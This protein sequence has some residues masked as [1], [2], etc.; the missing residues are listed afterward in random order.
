M[1]DA[2]SRRSHPQPQTG[3][4]VQGHRILRATD[5]NSGIILDTKVV[6]D[7]GESKGLPPVIERV[8]KRL[9]TS[10]LIR[11]VVDKGFAGEPNLKAMDRLNVQETVI[12]QIKTSKHSER[13]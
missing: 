6:T 3:G 12:P 7:S 11:V 4:Y 9:G 2:E 13:V 5:A 8:Q 10:T 1:T